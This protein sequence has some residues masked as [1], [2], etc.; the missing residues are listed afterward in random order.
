L[1]KP[2]ISSNRVTAY[3]LPVEG[4]QLAVASSPSSYAVGAPIYID[5]D[6][7]NMT[8]GPLTLLDPSQTE[9]DL[10]ISV[11]SN[12]K[13]A[14]LT[15]FGRANY[16]KPAFSKP[17]KPFSGPVRLEGAMSLPTQHS[18]HD[19]IL[20]SQLFDLSL[21][22]TYCVTVTQ[23]VPNQNGTGVSILVSQPLSILI[24]GDPTLSLPLPTNP[25]QDGG[26]S[27]PV[28]STF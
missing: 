6:L 3:S 17:Y 2:A 23:W 25:H 12:G 22:G 27:F 4:Y 11:T 28:G 16:V 10:N 14:P 7:K 21:Q 19:H 20:L 24:G 13:P 5:V 26:R 15:A 18:I 1:V 9:M 8:S